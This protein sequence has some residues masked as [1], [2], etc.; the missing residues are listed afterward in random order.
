MCWLQ[1][2]CVWVW[3]AGCGSS[4]LASLRR[5]KATVSWLRRSFEVIERWRRRR[6][7]LLRNHR[8]LS[9]NAPPQSQSS[10]SWSVHQ[11]QL[12]QTH[13]EPGLSH[14]WS[15][16]WW[17]SAQNIRSGGQVCH[18]RIALELQPVSLIAC[19]YYSMGFARLC[20]SDQRKSVCI[21]SA[22]M[23]YTFHLIST[24]KKR[25]KDNMLRWDLILWTCTWNDVTSK[26]F[27]FLYFASRTRSLFFCDIIFV[28][29]P[30]N[31]VKN[32]H[33]L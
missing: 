11:T 2:R 10:H 28:L 7:E 12:T 24:N 3:S 31:L 26:S 1:T 4:S 23:E 27:I 14:D 13:L 8:W 22:T 9:S 29:N 15:C 6:S 21:I 5:F 18:F 19:C 17:K 32:L 33:F 20:V 16:V 30:K 25:R